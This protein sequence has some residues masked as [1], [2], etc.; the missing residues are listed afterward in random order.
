[1]G[2]KDRESE[3]DCVTRGVELYWRALGQARG[4]E[5]CSGDIEYVISKTR[6]G[7]E[8][9]FRVDLAPDSV[10]SRIP[11]IVSGIKAGSL[12]DSILITPGARPVQLAEILAR[13]GFFIDQSTPCM[14]MELSELQDWRHPSDLVQ[15][16]TV[17]NAQHLRNWVD[18]VNTALFECEIMSFE[19]FF[20]IV[21]L[22]NTKCFLAFY[23][24]LPAAISMTITE[25]DVAT[26]EFVATCKEYRYRGLGRAVT[27]AALQYIK[28][29]NTRMVSLRAEADAIHLYR[30]LGF[31]EVCKRVVAAY[32]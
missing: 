21:S 9:I 2:L 10:E 20:D 6:S 28:E 3:L 4:M 12:P 8:R 11:E 31:R 30:Q 14:V 5:V 16:I 19:Q 26:L 32:E 24:G 7:P 22:P 27:T 18:I 13:H 1:M 29:A 23:D 15:V 25:G 17:G